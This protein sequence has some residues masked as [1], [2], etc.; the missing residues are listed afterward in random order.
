MTLC[1][2][3]DLDMLL[4]EVSMA[5]DSSQKRMRRGREGGRRGGR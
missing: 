3:L 1:G 5:R 4:L 2:S